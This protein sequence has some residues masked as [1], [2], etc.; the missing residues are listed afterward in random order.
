MSSQY[1]IGVDIGTGGTKAAIFDLNG[2]QLATAYEESRLLYPRTNW[3]EQKP[4]DF[5]MSTINTL[6]EAI[7]KSGIN[8]K[9]VASIAF[10]GQMAGILG[11]D[12][13]WN[14]VIPYDS[15]LDTRCRVQVDYLRKN[16]V[17]VLM[18]VT[19]APPSIAHLPK[20]LWWKDEEPLIFEKIYKF[21]VPSVYVAGKLAGLKGDQS[22]YDYTYITY[23]G[24]YDVK[25]MKW[26][27]DLCE[28]FRIPFDKLPRIVRP[29]EI[30]GELSGKEAERCGLVG[31]IPIVAGAGDYPASCLG[32]GITKIGLCLDV[33]G[34]ASILSASTDKVIPDKEFKTLLYT[35]AVVPELW[36]PHAYVGGGGLCLRWF[37]DEIARYEKKIAEETGKDP[38]QVLDQYASQVPEGSENLFFVPHLGGRIYPY[39]PRIKGVWLG[40]SWKHTASHLYRSILESI[41]YEYHYY[42]RIIRGLFK[43]IEFNEVR[44]I[45]GG[46]KSSVWNQIK[47]DV[48]NIPYVLLNREEYAV[49]G[50]AVLGGYAVKA[51]DSYIKTIDDW[52]KPVRKVMPSKERHEKYRKYADFYEQ[53][54]NEIDRI[55]ERYEHLT[56]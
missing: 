8:P 24:L 4:E 55:F 32:A 20:M 9:D 25:R 31:G 41:A 6:R 13:D 1:F 49:L 27:D 10:S 29:W 11:V 39:N 2:N 35:K 14:P 54:L 23:T 46:S 18:D 38:Y 15:W 43:N 33:A 44:G 3:V 34:T 36:I 28:I 30:I 40:F 56:I 45:G 12:K 26:S 21:T 50:L 22:F 51:F 37:R 17:D 42:F 19:A 7:K 47:A 48:L 52:V 53:M 5:Y 16:Y